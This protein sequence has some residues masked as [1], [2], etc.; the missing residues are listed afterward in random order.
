MEETNRTTSTRE[1]WDKGQGFEDPRE[2]EFEEPID[3]I[4]RFPKL[5]VGGPTGQYT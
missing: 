3:I 1:D 2:N 4:F 5:R